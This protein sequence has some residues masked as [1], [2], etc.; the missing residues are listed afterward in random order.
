MDLRDNIRRATSL[1]F[2]DNDA[3]FYRLNGLSQAAKD[4]KMNERQILE[5]SDTDSE[6][7]VDFIRS[8]VKPTFDKNEVSAAVKEVNGGRDLSN[9]HWEDTL[10]RNLESM[11]KSQK[12]VSEYYMKHDKRSKANRPEAKDSND[13]CIKKNI[14]HRNAAIMGL[15]RT[16]KIT[17]HD[18]TNSNENTAR[19]RNNVETLHGS[20]FDEC[21]G[22]ECQVE[23]VPHD[24]DS[25]ICVHPLQM[26][27]DAKKCKD[28]DFTVPRI[29]KKKKVTPTDHYLHESDDS[30]L[31][32]VKKDDSI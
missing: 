4:R 28:I 5:D 3:K 30:F 2:K 32:F 15:V 29:G 12:Q 21:D 16:K 1:T 24:E 20:T 18:L 22:D 25:E 9:K 6:D 27:I 31:D 11:T 23:S 8:K 19:R 10:A 14:F 17:L 13:K 26:G 7:N